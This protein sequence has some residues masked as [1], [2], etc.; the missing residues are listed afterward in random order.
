MLR[1]LSCSI[2]ITE[3]AGLPPKSLRRSKGV[4]YNEAKVNSQYIVRTDVRDDWHKMNDYDAAP[5]KGIYT[6]VSSPK[7]LYNNRR[8]ITTATAQ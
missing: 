1:K 5:C 6:W 4:P 8:L 7:A 3:S 2:A